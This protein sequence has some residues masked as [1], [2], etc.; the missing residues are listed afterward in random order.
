MIKGFES[1]DGDEYRC[2]ETELKL[3]FK[4]LVLFSGK[5]GNCLSTLPTCFCYLKFERWYI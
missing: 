5:Y 2:G 4:K 1:K 3:L